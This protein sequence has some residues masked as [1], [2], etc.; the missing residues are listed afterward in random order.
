MTDWP[1][2]G[3]ELT[4]GLR[5]YLADPT[6]RIIKIGEEPVDTYPALGQIRGVGIDLS[7]ATLAS[8][9]CICSNSRRARRGSGWRNR[10][11]RGLI[12]RWPA[13]AHRRS[14]TGSHDANGD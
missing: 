10:R 4:A 5:R 12:A 2:N 8:I 3:A 1:F 9:I 13:T 6:L 14:R 11:A 7:A